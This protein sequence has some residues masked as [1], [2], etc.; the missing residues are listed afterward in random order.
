MTSMMD[1]QQRIDAYTDV[2]INNKSNGHQMSSVR[3]HVVVQMYGMKIL[4]CTCTM[5]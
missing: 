5:L 1:L 3:E 4:A 2:R